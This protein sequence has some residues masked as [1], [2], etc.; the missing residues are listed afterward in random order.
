VPF[1]VALQSQHWA[2]LNPSAGIVAF[3]CPGLVLYLAVPLYWWSQARS[4]ER[5]SG[6]QVTLMFGPPVRRR[7]GQIPG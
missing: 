2:R 4:G 5:P 6:L 7:S 3:L 1:E